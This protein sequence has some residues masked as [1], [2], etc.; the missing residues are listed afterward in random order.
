MS[1]IIIIMP[2]ILY[3]GKLN[4]C[5]IDFKYA[6]TVYYV[7]LDILIYSKKYVYLNR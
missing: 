5:P 1:K 7:L 4:T 6:L 3:C 2:T